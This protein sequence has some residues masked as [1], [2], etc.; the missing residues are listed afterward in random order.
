M[1]REFSLVKFS[2]F[3]RIRFL[4]LAMTLA[5]LLDGAS[6]SLISTQAEEWD[7]SAPSAYSA[8]GTASARGSLIQGIHLLKGAQNSYGSK[9]GFTLALA[10]TGEGFDPI[11]TRAG[12]D[13]SGYTTRITLENVRWEGGS[14]I[15]KA[16]QQMMLM[17][18]FKSMLP[19][20]TAVALDGGDDLSGGSSAGDMPAILTLR[21]TL[22][23]SALVQVNSQ[24][25]VDIALSVEES[26]S[27]RRNQR[28]QAEETSEKP[29]RG[30]IS[31]LA[32][33]LR[34]P[35]RST[36][37]AETLIPLPKENKQRSA[38]Q[39]EKTSL[40]N[41]SA[42]ELPPVMKLPKVSGIYKLELDPTI[43][44]GLKQAWQ[45]YRQGNYNETIQY[46]KGYIASHP[47]RQDAHHLL[48]AAYLGQGDKAKAIEALEALTSGQSPYLPA[49]LDLLT[50]RIE[51]GSWYLSDTLVKKALAQ[52]PD[53][54]DLR[55]YN[56][57]LNEAQDKL[58][59]ARQEY[60]RALIVSP[61]HPF[62]HY[63]L[64]MVE[65][66]SQ[67]YEAAQV[68]LDRVLMVNPD[69][70]DALKLKAYLANRTNDKD[71]AKQ[72]YQQALRPDGMISY[73]GY[74][75][76]SGQS[77]QARQL[78]KTALILAPGDADVWYNVGMMLAAQKD[79]D[80]A[81]LV[82][83][84]YL[85]LSAIIGPNAAKTAQA[86]QILNQAH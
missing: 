30:K 58:D 70:T 48:A 20:V 18:Q 86:N 2:P 1:D 15:S 40:S 61:N 78:L 32:A 73:A 29:K 6:G 84:Q 69:N 31:G 3:D 17:A 45:A 21:S 5:L 38:G 27:K 23:L 36:M 71:K 33:A 13:Q 66:K 56:G 8:L 25:R 12:D 16:Q 19:Q 28:E 82:M 43:E 62:Y 75:Q 64:A 60:I 53:H 14:G 63:R 22:P 54:P 51:S 55:F 85:K 26:S 59:I 77:E 34:L 37:P 9:Q 4:T 42:V 80:E 35:K 67:R 74:L 68:E 39:P 24:S 46:L 7:D 65:L 11:I 44:S 83:K 10:Y 76:E 47:Q 41:I 50:L 79:W 81:K 49:V 52:W 72:Y 57:F